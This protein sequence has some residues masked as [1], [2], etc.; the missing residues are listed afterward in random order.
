MDVDLK[1]IFHSTPKNVVDFSFIKSSEHNFSI[2]LN[3]EKETESSI[4]V[5][6]L[7]NFDANQNID[8]KKFL[9]NKRGIYVAPCANVKIIHQKPNYKKL[10][11]KNY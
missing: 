10:K 4:D 7:Q 3:T 11:K 8:D 1:N 9:L 6:Q 2:I 5:N